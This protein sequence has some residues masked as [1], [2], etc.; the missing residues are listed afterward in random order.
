MAELSNIETVFKSLA[1]PTNFSSLIEK[2]QILN[3][4]LLMGFE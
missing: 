4:T 3:K 2:C 1:D